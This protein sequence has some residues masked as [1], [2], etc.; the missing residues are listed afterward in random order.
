ML[1]N[2]GAEIPDYDAIRTGHLLYVEYAN[3]DRE[4]YDLRDRPRR[5]RQPGRNPPGAGAG[6]W[7]TASSQLRRC[8]GSGCRL[9]ENRPFGGT[10]GREA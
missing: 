5:D 3:G 1:L 4:L 9:V 2:R 8:G 10:S 7:P 6:S